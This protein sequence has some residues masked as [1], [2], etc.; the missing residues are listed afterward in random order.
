ME[1]LTAAILSGLIYDGVKNG[2]T[3]SYE[4]LKSKLQG[5]IVDDNQ[6]NKIVEQLQEAGVNEDLAPHAME[7]KINDHQQLLEMLQQIQSTDS[8]SHVS[9][10]SYIGHNV[11]TVGNATISIGDVTVN[12]RND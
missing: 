3:I 12:K 4:L 11:N 8:N 1:Y 10:V 9:Q 6:L 7:R 2:A 5:W